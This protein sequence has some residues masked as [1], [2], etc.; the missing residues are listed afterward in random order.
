MALLGLGEVEDRR[1]TSGG[2]GRVVVV[3]RVPVRTVG[4]GRPGEDG[5]GH[6][7]GEVELAHEHAAL[8]SDHQVDVHG[9]A[10]DQPG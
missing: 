2:T 10:R 3:R 6:G 5:V 4:V 1:L 8:G 7:V 9:A